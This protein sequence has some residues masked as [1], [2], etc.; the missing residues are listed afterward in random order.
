MARNV[1]ILMWDSVGEYLDDA[2]PAA[3]RRYQRDVDQGGA[4]GYAHSRLVNA[5]KIVEK[6]RLGD[7]ELLAKAKDLLLAFE[8]QTVEEDRP[9]FG[10]HVVGGSLDIGRYTVGNPA[11]MRRRI[12][13]P[14]DFQRIRIYVNTGLSYGV[15]GG[16]AEGRAACIIGLVNRL[17]AEGVDLELYFLEDGEAPEGGLASRAKGKAWAKR[18]QNSDHSQDYCQLIRIDT[19]PVNLAQACYLM[20]QS[21]VFGSLMLPAAIE[22]FA[23]NPAKR[24][25]KSQYDLGRPA[26]AQKSRGLLGLGAHDLYIGSYH[27][28]DSHMKPAEW[29]AKY[30][31]QAIDGKSPT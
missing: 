27:V 26:W 5:R 13:A 17:Q 7:P 29:I 15:P 4:A 3:E 2:A 18:L 30:A 23:G 16:S 25:P 31:R 8:S 28:E 9:R 11:C 12:P 1:N 6:A 19:R 14:T 21:E 20:T 24:W 10:F 22:E